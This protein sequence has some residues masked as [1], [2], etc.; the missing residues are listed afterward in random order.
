M[1]GNG[2]VRGRP[3][4]DNMTGKSDRTWTVTATSGLSVTGYL[5]PWA[6]DDPSRTG[7]PVARMGKVLADIRHTAVFPGQSM[8]I[9]RDGGPGTDTVTLGGSI[10]HHPYTDNTEIPALSAGVPIANLQ[11]VDDYW[12]HDLDPWALGMIAAKLRAQ[13]DHLDRQVRPALTAAR[14]GWAASHRI[15]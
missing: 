10:D 11:I 5:P 1:T 2:T 12:V 15:S 13:A 6:E 14:A 8:R 7:V 4:S 3:C 9:A